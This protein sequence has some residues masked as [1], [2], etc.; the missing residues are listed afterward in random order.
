MNDR[1]LLELAAKAS[2]CKATDIFCGHFVVQWSDDCAFED[3]N[4]LEDD[5]DALRLAVTLDLSTRR[6]GNLIEVCRARVDGAYGLILDEPMGGDDQ[7]TVTRRAIV[8]AA[9]VIG[10]KL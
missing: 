4:P 2:G 3:W 5:G 8:R 9:A 10:A 6:F 7:L 1:E